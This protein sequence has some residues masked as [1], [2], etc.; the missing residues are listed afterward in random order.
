MTGSGLVVQVVLATAAFAAGFLLGRVERMTATGKT[1][2]QRWMDLARTAFGVLV[3]AVVVVS[4]W[5]DSRRVE[6]ERQWFVDAS[7]AIAERSAANGQT[8]TDWIA[9]ADASLAA[10]ER[11][12]RSTTPQIRD[13]LL[14]L[15]ES[16]VSVEEARRVAPIPVPP[17]C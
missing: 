5:Q 17:E 14:E 12:G 2:R 15:R 13:A 8:T 16:L 6:C 11:P 1:T 10:L 7:Q 9:F 3:I 4:Y